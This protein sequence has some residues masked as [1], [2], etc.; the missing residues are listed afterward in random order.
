M[1]D[2]GTLDALKQIVGPNGYW[3]R[4]EDMAPRL[5]EGRG[6]YRGATP[7]VLRPASTPEVSRIMEACHS[8]RVPVVP[9]G[10]NTGMVGGQIPSAD[11]T[12]IV[13]GLD[14]MTT[15]RSVDPL[16]NTIAVDAGLTLQQVQDAARQADRLFP[17]SL[18]A[19]GTCL[20]G[21]NLATNAGGTAVLRYG[22]MRELTLGLEV[23]LAD[24]RVL[25]LMTGLR[26]DNT[27]YDLKDLFIGSEGTLGIITGA[28]LKL[29]PRPRETETLMVAV[30]S[31]QAAVDLLARAQAAT[32]GQITA[33]EIMPR[34]AVELA[35][36][37]MD[38]VRDPFGAPHP[39]IALIEASSGH[40]GSLRP[41]LEGLIALALDD[42][43]V[44]DAVRAESLDQAA[45]LWA[46][47]EAIPPAQKKEGGSIKHD[48]SVPVSAMPAF[49]GEATTVAESLIP[50]A[51]VCA[52]GHI[53]D[54]NV[55]FNVSQPAGADRDEFL[56]HWDAMQTAIHAVVAAHGGAISAEHGIGQMKRHALAQ[57]KNPVALDTMKAIKQALDPLG[58]LNP[59]KLLP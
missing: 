50:G 18:G 41:A 1:I 47:R 11:G 35:T 43:L 52:F 28:V 49:I 9:Q 30:A 59:G 36:T 6:L 21:G 55:H 16:N 48:V 37:H 2:P 24:G 26:K 56:A 58:L 27:G 14:R 32:G 12:A 34:F 15:L 39:W 25:D 38:G 13:L 51:R 17:L 23:V 45:A 31:P 29:F 20:I 4:P 42:G 53:G 10:G 8:A 22:N 40:A 19:E 44:R 3:D 57:H 33:F 7:L 46:V 5:V 54:G